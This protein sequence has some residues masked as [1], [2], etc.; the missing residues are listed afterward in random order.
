M[1]AFAA[2]F[3]LAHRWLSLVLAGVLSGALVACGGGGDGEDVGPPPGTQQYPAGIWEGVVG[4]GTT[5]RP[6]IGFIDPGVDGKGGEFYFGRGAAGAAGYDSLYG[7]LRTEV[8]NVQAVGVSYYSVQDG[9]FADGLTLRGTATPDPLTGRTATISGSYARPVGTAAD[10][11]VP[12]SFK[13]NYSPLNN[14]PARLSLIAGAY[15][16]S[17]LFGGYW[18]LRI[19]RDGSVEGSIGNCRVG[20]TATP[21]SPDSALYSVSLTF[22]GEEVACGPRTQQMGVAMLRF[23]G[24]GVPNGIW[25]LTRSVVGQRDVYVLDGV[26]EQRDPDPDLRNALPAAGNWVGPQTLPA[27]VGGDS[28]LAGAV[29]P[30]GDFFFYTNT[31]ASHDAL[32]GDLLV[33]EDASTS[34]YFLSADEGVYFARGRSAGT[35]GTY[36][37]GAQFEATL[38]NV[39]LGAAPL[40]LVGKY[41]HPGQAGGFATL[42]NMEPDPLYALP[43][44]VVSNVNLIVGNYGM[45]SLNLAGT[46]GSATLNV[47]GFGAISGQTE[48]GCLIVGRLA[49]EPT[50]DRQ[51][52]NLYRVTGLNY[53]NKPNAAGCPLAGGPPQSG[54]AS[55]MF[56]AGGRVTGLRILSAGQQANGQRRHT[57]FLGSRL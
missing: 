40:R 1:R 57:V 51:W 29:L 7:M 30:D 41:S 48:H 2:S 39:G 26:A 23:D 42:F 10:R 52:R 33:R 3:P 22:S 21:R 53:L 20:G 28:G 17:G 24:N 16:G 12:E 4:S 8:T 32:Y 6:M 56:A 18:A 31:P 13:L 5:Q 37:G 45:A 25:V 35:P 38:A 47:D 34:T 36:V 55:A 19:A 46:G 43:P 54:V 27:G 9:K 44:G 49:A 50:S 15:R 11:G 14:Y